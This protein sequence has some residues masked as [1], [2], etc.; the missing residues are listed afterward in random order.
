[1]GTLAGVH[2]AIIVRSCRV[3]G[4]A[5]APAR[6]A[7]VC[8]A[9]PAWMRRQLLRRCWMRAERTA[10][11]RMRSVCTCSSLDWV[12]QHRL[13]DWLGF[14]RACRVMPTL[15]HAS[16]GHRQPRSGGW[17][18]R[19]CSCRYP[20]ARSSSPNGASPPSRAVAVRKH[21]GSGTLFLGM[22]SSTSIANPPQCGASRGFNGP[23]ELSCLASIQPSR[24]MRGIASERVALMEISH[25]ACS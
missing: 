5:G 8:C 1:M 14:H 25:M 22:H 18:R 24:L 16:L 11:K 20:P 3:C 6:L 21:S 13:R 10:R 12:I 19:C 9:L 23:S 2:P 7:A 17:R 15:G 4:G